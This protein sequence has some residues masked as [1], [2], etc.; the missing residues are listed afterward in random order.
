MENDTSCDAKQVATVPTC[1]NHQLEIE[2]VRNGRIKLGT[3]KLGTKVK[4][5]KEK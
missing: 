3:R 1:F 5:C 2:E 4:K